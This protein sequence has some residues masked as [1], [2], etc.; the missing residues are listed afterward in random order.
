VE[1]K[2]LLLPE[3]CHTTNLLLL[4]LVTELGVLTWELISPGFVWARM[5]YRS[6]VIQW[7]VLLSAG[8]LCRLKPVLA[9]QTVVF[10]WLLAFSVS[11]LIS[12]VVLI[13]GQVVVFGWARI[14]VW[15]VAQQIMAIAMILA[16]VL[17]Y[18]QLQQ[19]V[20]V[21]NKA[22]LN[23]RLNALQARIK[24]HFLFNSLNTIAEL[25]V[26]KPEAAEKA[27]VNLSN[28][29]RANLKET[30]GLSS[31]AQEI[32]L[33]RGYLS[34]EQWRLA[35]RLVVSWHLPEPLLDWPVPILSLQ[36]IVENAI[37]HGIAASEQG[38]N[39][40]I[41]VR[42]T[43]DRMYVVVSNSMA[44]ISEE[45]SGHGVALD[46]IRRRLAVIFGEESTLTIATE[47]NQYKVTL[48]FPRLKE[49][50]K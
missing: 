6:L 26:S 40:D 3:L 42:Q 2:H 12:S 5:G 50:S 13:S 43:T 34:I 8:A 23:S 38:G 21:Q 17:R 47:N 35:E 29:F 41:E 37:V 25:I 24:P 19:H 39:L 7:M 27:V 46:N 9:R 28:L 45:A 1:K 10:G 33:I 16:M 22:E 14:D 44:Q 31:I 36:P 20:I 48:V 11:L 4:I 30:E 15:Q 49:K 18:F 32:E